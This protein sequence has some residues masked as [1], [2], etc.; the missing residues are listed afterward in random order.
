VDVPR[1]GIHALAQLNRFNGEMM[2]V[3][4]TEIIQAQAFLSSSTGLFTE[5]AGAAAF[6]GFRKAAPGLD[7]DAVVV[8]LTTGNGLKDSTSA[9]LGIHIPETLINS[10]DDIL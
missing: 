10:V 3:S 6:A 2:T 4:D 9:T 8:V 7:P 5:P 1:N